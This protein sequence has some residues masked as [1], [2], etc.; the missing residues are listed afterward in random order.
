VRRR[1]RPRGRS[2]RAHLAATADWLAR[3]QEVNGDGGV[4]GRYHLRRGWSSS[5]PETTGYAIPTL[6]R[7]AKYRSDYPRLGAMAPGER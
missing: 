2:D 7:L 6:L 5:Y 1:M 3:A 4:A